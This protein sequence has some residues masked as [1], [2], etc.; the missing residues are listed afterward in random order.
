VEQRGPDPLVSVVM[1]AWNAGSS[2]TRAIE[3]VLADRRTPLECVVVD[4]GSTDDTA[5]V[6]A[7][8]ARRDPRVVPVVLE[9]NVG[10]SA[11]RNAGLLRARGRWLAFLDADDRLLPGGIEALLAAAARTDALVVIGQRILTDRVRSWTSRHYDNPDITAPGPKSLT[12]NPG[13]L[14]YAST[15]GKLFDRATTDGLSFEGRVLGDQPWTVR[16][17]IRAGSRIEVISDVVYEWSRPRAGQAATITSRSRASAAVAA[18]AARVAAR[19]VALV[20][21][22]LASVLG[23]GDASDA[24]LAAYVERH[25]RMDLSKSLQATLDRDD[26]AVAEVLD[27]I[28]VFVE[29]VPPGILSGS[30][31]VRD[32]LLVPPLHVWATLDEEARAAWARMAEP[33]LRLDPALGPELDRARR[34]RLRIAVERAARRARRRAGRGV[35]RAQAAARGIR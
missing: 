10:V 9:R 15:T 5:E 18:D 33:V 22:E 35:R 34:S 24:I 23:A 19:G 7:A 1:T 3:S 28:Q 25:V 12:R 13:L 30:R 26:P 11:A 6:V 20:G 21:D 4:D 8:I 17:L 2:V 27:A 29:A 16:A 32:G 14:Y 31:A